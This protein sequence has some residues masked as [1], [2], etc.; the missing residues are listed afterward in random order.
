MKKQLY[1]IL[2][3]T[4]LTLI[5]LLIYYLVEHQKN[6]IPLFE[7]FNDLNHLNDYNKQK[8]KLKELQL[9]LEKYLNLYNR[10][11]NSKDNEPYNSFFEKKNLYKEKIDHLSKMLD[12]LEMKMLSKTKK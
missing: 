12:T 2:I 9:E 3:T 7:L 10:F 4:F 5:G 6:K 1:F 8:E 11:I